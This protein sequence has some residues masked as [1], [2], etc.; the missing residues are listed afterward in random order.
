MRKMI[1]YQPQRLSRSLLGLLPLLLLILVY[2]MASDARLSVNAFDKLLPS[3]S[4]MGDALYRVAF[5]AD[6]RTGQ[7]LLWTDTY[8]ARCPPCVR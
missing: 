1:N 8:A 4:A 2:L 6:P 3:F 5:Q 7:Y